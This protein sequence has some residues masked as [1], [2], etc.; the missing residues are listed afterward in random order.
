MHREHTIY[1]ERYVYASGMRQVNGDLKTGFCLIVL[2]LDLALDSPAVS[3]FI[4]GT[5]FAMA[6]G[7]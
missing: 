6:V 2:I 5:M 7:L 4:V 1:M 3:A